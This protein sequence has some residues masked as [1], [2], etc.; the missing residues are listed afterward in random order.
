M[1]ALHTLLLYGGGIDSSTLVAY[2]AEQRNRYNAQL[3]GVVGEEEKTVSA[4]FFRYGQK[5]EALEQEACQRFCDKYDV[6][7]YIVDA[8][9]ASLTDSAIMKGAQ[10]ANDPKV[11]IL[12][13][14]N[15]T[16]IGLAGMLA[17]KIGAS[18]L[19]MGYHVEPVA[20]P[21]PDASI[22][23]VHA[24]NRMIPF[25]YVHHFQVVAPFAE[26]TREEIFAYAKRHAPDVLTFAHTC[27]EDVPGGCGVCTHCQLK[28]EILEKI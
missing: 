26:W 9:F 19:A 11:N 4:V 20:R 27:Y 7:L 21:F 23:F 25:A 3:E 16:F 22:E 2:L 28:K 18:K 13:G 5:A 12:D 8:P 6:P 24:I 10:L 14:R 15:F 1:S 17:A